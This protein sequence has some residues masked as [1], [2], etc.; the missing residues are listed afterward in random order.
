M[1]NV[2]IS[3]KPQS[4]PALMHLCMS[5]PPCLTICTR[6]EASRG[7]KR[8]KRARL[9]SRVGPSPT[10][11]RVA[12]AAGMDIE[13][14]GWWTCG[15]L[16]LLSTVR[17]F[18]SSDRCG[19]IDR[20]DGRLG[21]PGRIG[22]PS[23]T[24]GR[25]GRPSAADPRQVRA[26]RQALLRRP[27]GTSA[28]PVGSAGPRQDRRNIWNRREPH[29]NRRNRKAPLSTA[30]LGR[31]ERGCAQYAGQNANSA[32]LHQVHKYARWS[33]AFRRD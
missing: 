30:G 10:P 11:V 20:A 3:N 24:Y 13:R 18:A 2:Q 29:R 28:D 1:R 26:T 25:I 21:R 12:L 8:V 32:A 33:G 27:A 5:V 17:S 6:P 16:V 23:E 7:C 15:L 22:R 31:A 14:V 9:V 19:H 4:T